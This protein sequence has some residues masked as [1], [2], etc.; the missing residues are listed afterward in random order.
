[1]QISFFLIWN[2]FLAVFSKALQNINFLWKNLKGT[3]NNQSSV[4]RNIRTIES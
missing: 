3:A 2:Y 1:M 4:L